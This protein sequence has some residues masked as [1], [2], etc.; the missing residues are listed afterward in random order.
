VTSTSTPSLSAAQVRLFADPLRLRIVGLLAGEELCTC[1]LV[2]ETGAKQPTVSHHLRVLKEAGVVD[3]E[4]EGS[5][6]YYR[7]RAG[8]LAEL[9]AAFTALARQAGSP[10]RR[11]VCD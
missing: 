3:A 10:G 7:L 8:V 11:A 1:H 6:T 2:A 5:Y 4:P 9:G